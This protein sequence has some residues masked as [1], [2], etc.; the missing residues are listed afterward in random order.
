MVHRSATNKIN[1]KLFKVRTNLTKPIFCGAQI[2]GNFFPLG[3]ELSQ[4]LNVVCLGSFS[5]LG[6][7][8]H[9]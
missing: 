7:W 8:D 3:K 2:L 9:S 1:S 5:P 4:E 6:L